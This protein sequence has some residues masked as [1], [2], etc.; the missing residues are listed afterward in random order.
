MIKILKDESI[1]ERT[2]PLNF[3]SLS[4]KWKLIF[5][6]LESETQ[7]QIYLKYYLNQ[8]FTQDGVIWEAEIA[9]NS[10]HEYSEKRMLN[11]KY[12]MPMIRD[13]TKAPKSSLK[14]I[15]SYLKKDSN[16]ISI[17]Q[18]K[19]LLIFW[20][21]RSFVNKYHWLVDALTRLT[22]LPKLEEFLLV[23]P[24]IT[25]KFD[26]YESGLNWFNINKDQILFLEPDLRTKFNCKSLAVISTSIL[27]PGCCN[28]EG[29]KNLRIKI[30]VNNSTNAENKGIFINRRGSSFRNILNKSEFFSLLEKYQIDVLYA[31]DHSTE[32]LIKKINS[33][34]LLIGVM[35]A[36]L[37]NML[38]LQDNCSLIELMP[39]T[40]LG[41]TPD[42]WENQ[43]HAKY[44]GYYYYSLANACSLNYYF[45]PCG[46]DDARKYPPKANIYVNLQLMEESLSMI[47]NTWN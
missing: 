38:F 11:R 45:I 16:S 13:L 22:F 40:C 27:A 41:F 12:S 3:E 29:V 7:P 23:L 2:K 31:E 44:S 26:F 5:S 37:S 30:G 32:E 1:A 46:V 21:S 47:K 43:Y 14:R 36:G 19:T 4:N 18:D 6:E 35:G 33:A 9:D 10:F 28:V 8:A 15:Y 25:K 34:N 42:Y 39:E 24:E 17:E 20:D